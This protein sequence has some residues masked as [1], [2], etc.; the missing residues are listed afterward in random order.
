MRPPTHIQQRTAWSG[1]SESKCTQRLE[2]PGSLEIW[3]SRGRDREI[4]LKMGCVVGV[5]S[6]Y[7]IG[8]EWD[9]GGQTRR[10]I[11]T[12]L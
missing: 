5:G 10:G 9:G 7:G 6:R 4:L 11:K 12:G 1:L 3:W 2:A 8:S